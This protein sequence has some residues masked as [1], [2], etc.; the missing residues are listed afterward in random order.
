MTKPRQLVQRG[1]WKSDEL[2]GLKPTIY[3]WCRMAAFLDGE[4]H[5]DINPG[6]GS[7]GN[8]RYQ[9]RI[10]IGN[11]NPALPAWLIKTFGGTFHIRRITNRNAKD[12][13]IWNCMSGRAAWILYN[14]MPWF[15]M[16]QAQAE[17]LLA[18]QE[19]VDKTV[20][21]RNRVVQPTEIELRSNLKQQLA[22]LNQR[23]RIL[24]VSTVKGE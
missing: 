23:G 19:S 16:K 11:S 14:C 21:G 4:G 3:D 12:Q 15:I 1:T 17:L 18:L 2:E 20:Q 5:L 10:L 13:Y 9:T 22:K 7:S 8:L 24:P 6:R